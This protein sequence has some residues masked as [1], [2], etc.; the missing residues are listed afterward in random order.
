MK[1]VGIITLV[2]FFI[3]ILFLVVNSLIM[4]HVPRNSKFGMWYDRN[5]TSFTDLEPFDNER[6]K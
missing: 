5:I 4:K 3:V 1:I 6:E 2:L